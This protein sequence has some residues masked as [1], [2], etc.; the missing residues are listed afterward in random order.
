FA[1]SSGLGELII[2]APVQESTFTQRLR[3]MGLPKVFEYLAMI[4]TIDV[5]GLSSVLSDYLSSRLGRDFRILR[6]DSCLKLR[7]GNEETMIDRE[8]T[9]ARVL[10]GPGT[11]SQLV[12]GFS[13]GTLSALD[14]T[15]PIPLFIWGLDSV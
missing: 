14:S 1:A 4:R 7:V 10:F 8:Q 15:L 3:Q 6:A 5:G 9:L 11:P 12:R 13:D 2:L